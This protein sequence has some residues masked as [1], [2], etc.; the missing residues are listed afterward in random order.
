MLYKFFISLVF[1]LILNQ[2]NGQPQGKE[3]FKRQS[4]LWQNIQR[5]EY[6]PNDTFPSLK[7]L[8]NNKIPKEVIDLIENIKNKDAKFIKPLLFTGT[9]RIG[10]TS[11]AYRIAQEAKCNIVSMLG[12]LER[13]N[14]QTKL[15]HLEEV[16]QLTQKKSNGESFILCLDFLE[17]ILFGTPDYTLDESVAVL[18]KI[19]SKN[20]ISNI[21]LIAIL[22]D[23][24]EIEQY[25]K[26]FNTI[27]L[28]LPSFKTRQ[29]IIKYYLK[30]D[31]L[32]STKVRS[33]FLDDLAKATQGFTGSGFKSMLDQAHL[34]FKF[35]YNENVRWYTFAWHNC[36]TNTTGYGVEEEA[37]KTNKALTYVLGFPG[38]IIK[39]F[40]YYNATKEEA[41]I[42]NGYLYQCVQIKLMSR[43][44]K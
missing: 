41:A 28:A 36:N 30:D 4:E 2:L 23:P 21:Y 37:S 39:M 33:E 20:G 6:G 12:T 14:Y 18:E 8:F 1:A 19:L 42:Y 35:K 16:W 22:H 24:Y 32:L 13:E 7:L 40:K 44:K 11:A 27:S 29:N 25:G 5:Q 43:C 3:D 10:K 17:T 38:S 9:T 26:L 31:Q 34:L 15:E